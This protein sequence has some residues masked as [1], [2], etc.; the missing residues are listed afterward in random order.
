MNYYVI[1]DYERILT[2]HKRFDGL[3]EAVKQWQFLVKANEGKPISWLVIS[4]KRV[5]PDGHVLR[6]ED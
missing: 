6:N 4:T 1:R 2:V 5:I 3:D